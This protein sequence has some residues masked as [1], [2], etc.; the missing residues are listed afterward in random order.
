VTIRDILESNLHTIKGNISKALLRSADK[1]RDVKI[2]PITKNRRI[3]E[4]LELKNLGFDQIGENRVFEIEEKYPYLKHEFKIHLV[5]KLQK[6]KVKVA[7]MIVDAIHSLDNLETAMMLEKE[8]SKNNKTMH[9]FVE[10]NVSGELN[11]SGI[12]EKDLLNF[13]YHA[14]KFKFLKI[15]GFMTMPPQT[16]NPQ[17]SRP[18]FR[19]LKELLIKCQR[20]QFENLR[21]TELSMGTSQDYEVAVEEGATIIRLGEAIF[22]SIL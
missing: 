21:L 14:D 5:G 22:K 16:Q 9:A 19:K 1:E 15:K 10:V 7:S 8:L 6:N 2:L 18:Y 12:F 3:S 4:I 17:S 11:K 20:E 13:L